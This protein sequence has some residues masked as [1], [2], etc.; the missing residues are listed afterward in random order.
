MA[1]S[2]HLSPGAR[3]QAEWALLNELA[4]LLE[5]SLE[6]ITTLRDD[7]KGLDKWPLTMDAR[8]PLKWIAETVEALDAL[9][10]Q[11]IID[12]GPNGEDR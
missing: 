3:K 10:W 9:G 12:R 6:S 11:E 2:D 5:V 4:S 7:V 8:G 1:V